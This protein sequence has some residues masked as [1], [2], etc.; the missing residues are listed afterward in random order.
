MLDADIPYIMELEYLMLVL[1]RLQKYWLLVRNSVHDS[2]SD[3]HAHTYNYCNC[4]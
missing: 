3:R 4:Q 2:V 1:I